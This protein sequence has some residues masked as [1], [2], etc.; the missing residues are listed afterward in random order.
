VPSAQTSEV[1]MVI[2]SSRLNSPREAGY[3]A[4]VGVERRA[5]SRVDVKD[6]H[7]VSTRVRFG[8]GSELFVEFFD[9]ANPC[10]GTGGSGGSAEAGP[11]TA[12]S[13]AVSAGL[14]RYRGK[15]AATTRQERRTRAS[16]TQRPRRGVRLRL[17]RPPRRDPRSRPLCCP[18]SAN[19]P[20]RSSLAS[21][22][23]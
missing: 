18:C 2:S 3:E 14:S 23:I 16:S 7:P 19:M 17:L 12:V 21:S 5:L 20:V 10:W 22:H 1:R 13:I 15:I 6:R 9:G 4:S 8:D 11:S